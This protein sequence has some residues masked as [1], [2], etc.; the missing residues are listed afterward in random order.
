MPILYTLKNEVLEANKALEKLG[1]VT[2]TW[3]N[4]SGIDRDE[5]IV[6]IK[7]WRSVVGE[8]IHRSDVANTATGDLSGPGACIEL[9]T[10]IEKRAG[11]MSQVDFHAQLNPR[12]LYQRQ[13]SPR[14]T[15]IHNLVQRAIKVDLD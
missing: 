3:G 7:D 11:V 6:V 13:C 8:Q 5:G 10:I 4:V 12:V 14:G 1:L 2:F 9:L 15:G